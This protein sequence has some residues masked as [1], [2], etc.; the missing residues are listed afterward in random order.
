MVATAAVAAA[1]LAA[2]SHSSLQ[3]SMLPS[4]PDA[5]YPGALSVSGMMSQEEL[6]ILE[7]PRYR[8]CGPATRGSSTCYA[9]L[10]NASVSP[11]LT[12]NSGS[13][14]HLPGCYLP[15]DL[16]G[17]YGI[18]SAAH[19]G[20]K[21][22]TVAVVDAFGYT[23]GYKGLAKDLATY[24]KFAGLPKCDKT[25]F[26]ILDQ[27]G[28]TKLPKPG[29]GSDAGWQ[30]EEALDIDMV[31]A[32]CPNCHIL[33]VQ[34][35]SSQNTDLAK[36]E[37]IALKKASYVS[38]SWGG[39]EELPTYPLF[40]S[41]PGKVITASAGDD[42]AGA[43]ASQG[44]GTE[45]QPCGF[46]G[47]VCVGGTSLVAHNGVYK[48]ETVW[49]DFH[50]KYKGTIYNF[51]AT[52]SGCS[53]MVAKPSWQKDKGCTKRSAT[54]ISA[55]ADPV[56]GVVIACTPCGTGSNEGLLGGVGG[57]SASSPMIA[58]MYAL[59]GNAKSIGSAPQ[60]IWTSSRSNFND[61]TQGFN[62]SAKLRPPLQSGD[63]RT[64]LI[65]GKSIA[66][67]CKAGVGYDGPTGWGSP[68]G[69]GAL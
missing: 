35:N 37:A 32:I 47:V 15:I 18:T 21:G 8:A 28:K 63:V 53:S 68:K 41:H 59:A 24:R 11:S 42:G 17:A 23:G 54:D 66:Y 5:Q 22:E 34:T 49:Q 58:S 46:T 56:T 62:D 6:T 57:T 39:A 43:P 29:I 64:G 33:L 27:N 10:S 60:K 13:C 12:P 14:V 16:Q 38:N 40:D 4:G 51:G 19:S 26:K 20:G 44:G 67:I 30:G 45:S 25:C 61:V 50:Y 1:T 7:S 36:G 31:S 2:C 52:G 3:Q 69:L 48:A 9:I 55:D 65:C